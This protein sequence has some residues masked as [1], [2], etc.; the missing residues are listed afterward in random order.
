[1]I[2]EDEPHSILQDLHNRSYITQ[3]IQFNGS[4]SFILNSLEKIKNCTACEVKK[5]TIER[6]I[7]E[8]TLHMDK[9][10]ENPQAS[11]DSLSSP[12]Y[13]YYKVLKEHEYL[14]KLITLLNE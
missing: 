11:P 8:Y 10:I 5:T 2:F 4:H 14:K 13:A 12:A 1:M 7:T 3:A 6:Y 9:L